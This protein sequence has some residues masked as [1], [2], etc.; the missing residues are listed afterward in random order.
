[1]VETGPGGETRYTM[2]ESIW[3]YADDKLVEQGED[4][5]F[6][7]RHLDYFAAM[8]EE[9]E[10]HL[11]GHEQQAWLEKLAADHY[12]LNRALR[13]SLDTPETVEFG[14]RLAGALTAL[15]GGAQLPHRGLRAFPGA[16]GQGGR[17]GRA[18]RAREGAL[19]LRAAFLGAG[20]R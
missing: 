11:Y 5:R 18:G 6:R 19:R 2:L 15:L 7:R 17:V 20:P 10:P 4:K 12:N 16:A 3:D 14:L 8:A 9:A 13:T 1:M